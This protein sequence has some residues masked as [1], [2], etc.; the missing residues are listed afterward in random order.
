MNRFIRRKKDFLIAHLDRII[1]REDFYSRNGFLLKIYKLLADS[2]RKEQIDILTT[3]IVEKNRF[4]PRVQPLLQE[5]GIVIS[6]S[7]SFVKLMTM[8]HHWHFL[9]KEMVYFRRLIADVAADHLQKICSTCSSDENLFPVEQRDFYDI[10][11]EYRNHLRG[12]ISYASLWVSFYRKRQ[13]FKTL[14][15]ECKL[16]EE[17]KSFK[18]QNKKKSYIESEIDHS[19]LRNLYDQPIFKEITRQEIRPPTL[20]LFLLWHLSA[21]SNLLHR[22]RHHEPF[23]FSQFKSLIED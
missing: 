17:I 10:L 12:L 22:K 2:V 18:K 11:R 4:Q 16:I 14:C 3:Q 6:S 19:Q 21:K 5:N 15:K 8:L 1:S 7:G 13:S 9:G 20:R 23:L